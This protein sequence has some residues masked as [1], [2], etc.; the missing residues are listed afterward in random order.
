MKIESHDGRYEGKKA[1][2]DS[3]NWLTYF[4]STQFKMPLWYFNPL[5]FL[6]QVDI[7]SNVCNNSCGMPDLYSIA[8]QVHKS[9][10]QYVCIQLLVF[11]HRLNQRKGRVCKVEIHQ[12]LPN[13]ICQRKTFFKIKQLSRGCADSRVKQL[14][15]NT[16]CLLQINRDKKGSKENLNGQ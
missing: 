15:P 2:L 12:F 10:I 4:A 7:G 1:L 13:E 11:S 8:T 6:H 16:K 3:P 5:K 9:N 14:A